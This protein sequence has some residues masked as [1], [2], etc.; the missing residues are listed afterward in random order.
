[1]KF[2]SQEE[3]SNL[4]RKDLENEFLTL[5]D[6]YQRLDFRARVKRAEEYVAEKVN[7]KLSDSIHTSYDVLSG[8]GHK[9]EV[10]LSSLLSPNKEG[11]PCRGLGHGVAYLATTNERL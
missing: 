11:A 9:L 3:L 10:I 1:V 2:Y 6:N 4:S 8:S 7:G 5:Q